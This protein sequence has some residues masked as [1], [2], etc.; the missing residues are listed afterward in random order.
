ML[1]NGY[2]K[3]GHDHEFLGTWYRDNFFNSV[4]NVV[5]KNATRTGA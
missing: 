4:Y 2:Y 1:L 3:H 5:H